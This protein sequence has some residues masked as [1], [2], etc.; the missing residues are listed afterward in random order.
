MGTKNTDKSSYG[1]YLSR[2]PAQKLRKAEEVVKEKFNLKFFGSDNVHK[3]P[4]EQLL[5][6]AQT[7]LENDRITSARLTSEKSTF[8]GKSHYIL[9]AE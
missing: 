6:Y 7:L 1:I 3:L 8:D 9:F 5:F 2:E 4:P